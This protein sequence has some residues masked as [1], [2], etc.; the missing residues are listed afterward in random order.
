M[1]T[2]VATSLTAGPTLVDHT[3]S[4]T[5]CHRAGPDSRGRAPTCHGDGRVTDLTAA[6]ASGALGGPDG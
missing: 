5:I 3:P 6:P 2:I 1:G 4:V